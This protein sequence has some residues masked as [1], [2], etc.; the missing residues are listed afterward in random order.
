[1]EGPSTLNFFEL[2][3]EYGINYWIVLGVEGGR[4]FFDEN[5]M[6]QLPLKSARCELIENIP[7]SILN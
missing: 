4:N 3:L 1:M 5:S 6:Q 7:G 2:C